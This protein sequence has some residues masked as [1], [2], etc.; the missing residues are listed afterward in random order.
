[1]DSGR[2]K[3]GVDRIN[4]KIQRREN[5]KRIRAPSRGTGKGSGK[6]EVE[7]G[8]RTQK[9]EEDGAGQKVTRRVLE[10][11]RSQKTRGHRAVEYAD[12]KIERAAEPIQ[13][14]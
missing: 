1:M 4:S 11:K 13:T 5:E 2:G 14:V 12:C 8:K 6:R 3:T 7:Q 9:T 10:T